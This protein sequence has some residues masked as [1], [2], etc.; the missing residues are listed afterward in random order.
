TP[1]PRIVGYRAVVAQ[2]KVIIG[3]E[4]D[5][6]QRSVWKAW[7]V[8]QRACVID[9]AINAKFADHRLTPAHTQGDRRLVCDCHSHQSVVGDGVEQRASID[10]YLEPAVESGRFKGQKLAACRSVAKRVAAIGE[11]LFPTIL[12]EFDLALNRDRYAKLEQ[13][14]ARPKPDREG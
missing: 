4:L 3:P 7:R 9:V 8:R 2:D 5:T 12:A 14:G 1:E 11:R 10:G 6:R 13:V